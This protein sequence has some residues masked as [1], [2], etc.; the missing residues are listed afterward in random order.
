MHKGKGTRHGVVA[1]HGGQDGRHTLRCQVLTDEISSVHPYRQRWYCVTDSDGWKFGSFGDGKAYQAGDGIKQSRSTYVL[2]LCPMP[3]MATDLCSVGQVTIDILPDDMLLEIFS[4]YG[5]ANEYGPW[6]W[7]PFVHVCRRWRQAIFASPLHLR[8]VLDCNYRSPVKRLLNIW[9]RLPIAIRYSP[10]RSLEESEETIAAFEHRDRVSKISIRCRNSLQWER[11]ATTMLKPFPALGLLSLVSSHDTVP[12][13]PEAFLGGFAPSLQTMTLINIAFPALPKL[14]LSATHLV[15]LWL[16]TIP[17]TGYISPEA[18][19]ACLATS[20]NL[21]ELHMG[22]QFGTDK[23]SPPP[24]TRDILPSLTSFQFT[25]AS[26]YLEQFVARIET[27]RL[28]TLSITFYDLILP[29][30]QLHRFLSLSNMFKSC[31]HGV[32]EFNSPWI[33]LKLMPRD[34]HHHLQMTYDKSAGQVSSIARV[35]RALSPLLSHVERL[36]LHERP[37]PQPRWQDMDPTQW[38]E[39]FRPFVAVQSLCISKTLVPLIA[40]ALRTLTGERATEV[41]PELRTLF[42][43]D[44]QQA[45]SVMQNIMAFVTMRQLSG[46]PVAIEQYTAFNPG[47]KD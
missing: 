28:A 16:S 4:I 13:L 43:Q 1:T 32:V 15:S 26:N 8:L 30:P 38:L 23:S 25:G 45:G 17:I 7:K 46:H 20:S 29:I 27:P 36:D 41:L 34:S 11:L 39:L 42:L 37:F 35:C 44:P 12:L 5:E 33:D 40:S 10:G 14:L 22:F 3:P 6:W 31:N 2:I 47:T 24:S 9:P 19:A 18:M 21:N